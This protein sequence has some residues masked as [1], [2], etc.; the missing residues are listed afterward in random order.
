L[1]GDKENGF[2]L[3]EKACDERDDYVT[4]IKVDPVLRPYRSD[5]RYADL[6]RRMG[7]PQ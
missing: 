1:T 4:Y 6:L 3:L 7:L 5:P 2:R